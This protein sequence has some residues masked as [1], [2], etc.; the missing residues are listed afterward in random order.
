MQYCF[1]GE[2]KDFS[3]YRGCCRSPV[4]IL[5]RDSFGAIEVFSE[6]RLDLSFVHGC[7]SACH[8][9]SKFII[10]PK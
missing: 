2:E 1:S 9:V 10:Q 7:L 6:M 8:E 3:M 5:S 4:G